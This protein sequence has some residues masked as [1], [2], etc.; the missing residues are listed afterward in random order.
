VNI[1]K[2]HIY[3]TML[4]VIGFTVSCSKDVDT[5]ISTHT[6]SPD[7]NSNDV[8]KVNLY[9]N[10][11]YDC[12]RIEVI[13]NNQPL[14]GLFNRYYGIDPIV[15]STA[16]LSQSTNENHRIMVGIGRRRPGKKP[17]YRMV[18]ISLANS[19]VNSD[20]I[21]N[22]VEQFIGKARYWVLLK[23]T[24]MLKKTCF[25]RI[26]GWKVNDYIVRDDGDI[27]LL[28]NIN[29]ICEAYSAEG[30]T[31][32]DVE[33]AKDIS[34]SIIEVYT[35]HECRG[36]ASIISNPNDIHGYSMNTFKSEDNEKVIRAP[37][38]DPEADTSTYRWNFF[39]YNKYHGVVRLFTVAFKN[40]DLVSA[41]ERIIEENIGEAYYLGCEKRP[42]KQTA[43]N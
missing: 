15:D 35:K 12:A 33:A 38:L 21:Y 1:L 3:I 18:F 36:M 9:Y 5:L 17:G 40:G 39:T 29:S 32:S 25:A 27:S 7:N 41:Q 14:T 6:L 28:K 37:W 26:F 23:H 31:A 13:K 8:Y 2:T 19:G 30:I 43:N 10:G 11:H 42:K 24:G 22:T 34:Q 20:V 16:S 4:V